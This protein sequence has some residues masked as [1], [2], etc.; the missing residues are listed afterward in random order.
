MQKLSILTQL[1]REPLACSFS[2]DG[3][4]SMPEGLLTPWK[5]TLLLGLKKGVIKELII[6]GHD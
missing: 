5:V 6:M 4:V 2:E 1:V 3:E